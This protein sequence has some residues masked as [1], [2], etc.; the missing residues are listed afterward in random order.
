MVARCSAGDLEK[1]KRSRKH[2]IEV[3]SFIITPMHK[4][5]PNFNFPVLVTNQKSDN[6]TLFRQL[7]S[8]FEIDI[9]M[10]LKKYIF[11]DGIMAVI[12]AQ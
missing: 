2:T 12:S 8:D 10:L 4:E 6:L 3:F 11:I 5:Q 9:G 1:I 7:N